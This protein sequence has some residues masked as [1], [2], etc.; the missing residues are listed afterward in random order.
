M[1]LP[2]GFDPE[3]GTLG[4]VGNTIRRIAPTP[5]RTYTNRIPIA[6]AI[7]LGGKDLVMALLV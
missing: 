5:I 3:T 6:T 7:V 4:R 1:A 2:S